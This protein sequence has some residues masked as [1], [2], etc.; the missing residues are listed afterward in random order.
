MYQ[1][2][3]PCLPPVRTPSSD[4]QHSRIIFPVYTHWKGL[5]INHTLHIHMNY[6][7]YLLFTLTSF[8]LYSAFLSVFFLSTQHYSNSHFKFTS[9]LSLTHTHTQNKCLLISTDPVKISH[10]SIIYIVPKYT[11]DCIVVSIY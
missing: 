11:N 8:I 3:Y 10:L 9:S 2:H 7:D 1:T 6:T 5:V 4:S